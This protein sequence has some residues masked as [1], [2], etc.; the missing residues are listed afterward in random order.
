MS[1]RSYHGATSRSGYILGAELDYSFPKCAV[2]RSVC[3]WGVCV[4]VWG[5][6]GG[7]GGGGGDNVSVS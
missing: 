5:G 7:G 2:E 4:C 3:V 1:E 6:G